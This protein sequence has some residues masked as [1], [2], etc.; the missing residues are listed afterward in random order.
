[1]LPHVS[2]ALLTRFY[3]DVKQTIAGQRPSLL[4]FHYAAATTFKIILQSY[5]H[6]ED[7]STISLWW[8]RSYHTCSILAKMYKLNLHLGFKHYF[9]FFPIF[10]NFKLLMQGLFQQGKNVG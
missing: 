2:N 6:P 8:W 4:R 7:C 9:H 3:H 5:E 1:M 10:P